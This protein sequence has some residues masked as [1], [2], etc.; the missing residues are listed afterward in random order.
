MFFDLF[1]FIFNILF[2]YFLKIFSKLIKLFTLLNSSNIL[3][4]SLLFGFGSLVI[5]YTGNEI[6]TKILGCFSPL[7]LNITAYTLLAIFTLD[8]IYSCMI[9]YN[10][11]NRIIICEELKNEKIAKLPGMLEKIMKE[12]VEKFKA[13]P[14]RLLEA[15]PNLKNA[16]QKEFD[17]MKMVRDKMKKQK[18]KKK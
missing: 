3:F 8:F 16:N 6:I 15:F 1:I 12:R 11:R 5:I 7:V 17:I 9:A 18:K 4:N 2:L 10:L 14:K 13:Y